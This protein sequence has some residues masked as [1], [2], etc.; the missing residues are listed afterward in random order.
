MVVLGLLA[1]LV[2]GFGLLS[3]RVD[4]TVVSAPMVFV[5]AGLV[6][7]WTG[8]VD[9]GSATHAEPDAAREAVFLVAELALVLL[10][11]TDAAR[12]DP[13]HLRRNALPLRL[14]VIG[15]PLTI[16]LGTLA[17]LVVLSDLELWECAIVAAV[18]APTD[19]ALG[20]AVVSSELVPLRIREGLNVES[21]L[22]DGGSV[23][24][25]MLFIALA[26]SQ[27]G[28]EEGWLQFAAEQ[29][30]Y[31]ALIGVAVGGLGALAIRLA[32]ARGWMTTVFERLALAALAIIAWYV[33]DAAGGNGFI[34][35]FV[36][37]GAAGMMA[38]ALRE[39]LLDFA[40]EEGE[41]LNLAVF[42]IFG[43]FAA[44]ALGDVTLQ[45]VVYGVLSLTVIRMLPVAVA[46]MGLGLRPASVAFVGWFGPAWTGVRHP[47]A[48]RGRG[49][50]RAQ[51]DPGDLPRDDDHR[52]DERVRA[53]H[54]R[55]AADPALRPSRPHAR[56][57]ATGAA[58]P[59][60][61]GIAMRDAHTT[62][63]RAR[64]CLRDLRVLPA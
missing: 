47:R 23:P 36:G 33:A 63:A 62:P 61:G 25:L 37:G 18:L 16:G 60:G 7:V 53:R 11:F 48:R 17:A 40:E 42:F 4:G 21:G 57:P 59:R 27:E 54:Q 32:A 20:K 22:N 44:E 19:A 58:R 28:L 45:M 50:G 55:R 15:L 39:R 56:R 38:G 3:R 35:A 12:I 30:G 34:A 64:T 13:R 10:L 5:T 31:G 26:A 24:F 41:L 52:A 8:L 49:G 1:C 43:F 6:A 29:I 46:V 9:L 14:L 2:F 51:R